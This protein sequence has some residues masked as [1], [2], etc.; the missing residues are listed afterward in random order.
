M[1]EFKKIMK[2]DLSEAEKLMQS[3][4]MIT[5]SIVETAE[6]EIELVK[7][8][9]DRETL[10]KEQIKLATVRHA[11]SIFAMCYQG[12]TGKKAWNE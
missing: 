2:T 9:G 5:D 1:E 6:Q 8:M 11:R 12:A 7:A 10:V 4:R 3:F